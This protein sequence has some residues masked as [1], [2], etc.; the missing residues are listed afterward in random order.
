MKREITDMSSRVKDY[1]PPDIL[2][3]NDTMT[4]ILQSFQSQERTK[5]NSDKYRELTITLALS[6]IGC[7]IS[8]V[9]AFS[10]MEMSWR[11]ITG[12]IIAILLILMCITAFKWYEAYKEAKSCE[13]NPA[14][15]E[16][17]VQ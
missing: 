5:S 6:L 4:N 9:G 3:S 16:G 10:A 8:L 13:N 11:V 2:L 12:I 14:G 7:I 17:K 15:I 1:T